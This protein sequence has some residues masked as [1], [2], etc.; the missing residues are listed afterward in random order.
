MEEYALALGDL[1]GRVTQRRKEGL[2]TLSRRDYAAKTSD[3]KP[4]WGKRHDDMIEE[5]SVRLGFREPPPPKEP[6]RMFDYNDRHLPTAWK[7]RTEAWEADELPDHTKLYRPWYHGVNTS[8]KMYN[9]PDWWH[10]QHVPTPLCK[11]MNCG[12]ENDMYAP[13]E[14]FMCDECQAH[15]WRWDGPTEDT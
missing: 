8:V 2:L 6:D 11:C 1:T 14:D 10:I 9:L 12:E 3:D 13:R 15:T 5:I 7:H 4:G